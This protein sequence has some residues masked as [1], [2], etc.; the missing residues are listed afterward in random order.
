[1]PIPLL[2][3]AAP[4]IIG[5]IQKAISQNKANSME[6]DMKFMMALIK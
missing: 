2:I 4:L 6:N 3:V 1:M 5:G